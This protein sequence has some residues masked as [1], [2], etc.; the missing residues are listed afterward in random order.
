MFRRWSTRIPE[1][2]VTQKTWTTSL[3]FLIYQG[4]VSLFVVDQSEHAHLYYLS[5]RNSTQIL[6]SDFSVSIIRK[7]M[8]IFKLSWAEL[9]Q[10]YPLSCQFVE[11]EHF[12]LQLRMQLF[13]ELDSSCLAQKTLFPFSKYARWKKN[14]KLKVPKIMKVSLISSWE[15]NDNTFVKNM[16]LFCPVITHPSSKTTQS[17]R[18]R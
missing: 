2:D 3:Y 7:A 13:I 15:Y 12:A 17:V 16:P 1:Q 14:W 8:F 11:F 4:V 10:S 6:R 9:M 18:K 5:N